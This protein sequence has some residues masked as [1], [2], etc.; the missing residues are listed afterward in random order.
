MKYISPTFHLFFKN[1]YYIF[2]I[3]VILFLGVFFAVTSEE[4]REPICSVV[5]EVKTHAMKLEYL[6]EEHA[7]QAASI[8]QRACETFQ[9][10]YRVGSVGVLFCG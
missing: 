3:N 6:R 7:G 1:D 9:Q 5:R 8:E 4:Q 10:Q 2:C